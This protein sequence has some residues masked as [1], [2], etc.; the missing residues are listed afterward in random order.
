MCVG[1]PDNVLA[2]PA[3]PPVP[4]GVL[5]DAG[6]DGLIPLDICPDLPNLIDESCGCRSDGIVPSMAPPVVPATTVCPAVLSGGCSVC[7]SGMCVGNPNGIVAFPG[8]PTNL[9]K[10]VQ[11]EVFHLISV[12]FSQALSWTSAN[13]NFVQ[14]HHLVPHRECRRLLVQLCLEVVVPFAG[15]ACVSETQMPFLP[16]LDNPRFF[17]ASYKTRASMVSFHSTNVPSSQT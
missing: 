9:S 7:G 6:L 11:V 14:R 12:P 5:Q 17:A 2:F 8:Q 13:V 15:L 16:F 10:L 3:Q 1:Y 4:C